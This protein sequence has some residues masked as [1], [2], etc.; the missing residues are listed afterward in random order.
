MHYSAGSKSF[1]MTN[2]DLCLKTQN[3]G[4][5]AQTSSFASWMRALKICLHVRVVTQT[6][7]IE[8]K[9]YA[10]ILLFYNGSNQAIV[11]YE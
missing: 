7:Y 9:C 11:I 3:D 8:T 6:F 4:P 1:D 10:E 2:L 5:W